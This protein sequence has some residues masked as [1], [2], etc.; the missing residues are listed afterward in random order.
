MTP[1]KNQNRATFRVYDRGELDASR[2]IS[3]HRIAARNGKE[4]T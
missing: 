1:A 2:R 4:T 3:E